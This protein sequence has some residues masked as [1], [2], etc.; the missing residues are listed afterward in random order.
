VREGK[1]AYG[2][3]ALTGEYGDLVKDMGIGPKKVTRSA[4]ENA[5]SVAAVFLTPK[6]SWWTC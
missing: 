5:V 6:L 3:N 2:Y 4:L 1:D